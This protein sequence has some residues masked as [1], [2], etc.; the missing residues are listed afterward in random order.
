MLCA[1]H[2]GDVLNLFRP[3]QIYR[4]NFAVKS[5]AR[6]RYP[7]FG[8]RR[9][10]CFETLK[11]QIARVGFYVRR[12]SFLISRFGRTSKYSVNV[13]STL[14]YFLILHYVWLFNVREPSDLIA[15]QIISNTTRFR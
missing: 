6:V 9:C 15:S 7:R 12:D 13:I 4:G 1:L 2:G 3:L 10:A 5:N 14:Y 11:L 8:R